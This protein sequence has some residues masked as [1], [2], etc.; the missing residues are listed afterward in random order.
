[1]FTDATDLTLDEIRATLAP[2]IAS[3]AAFDND[4]TILP[5]LIGRFEQVARAVAFKRTTAGTETYEAE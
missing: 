4:G 5:I 1:M 3:N 2:S